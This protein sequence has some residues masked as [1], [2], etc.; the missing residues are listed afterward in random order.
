MRTIL[1]K[2]TCICVMRERPTLLSPHAWHVSSYKPQKPLV[3]NNLSLVL[4]FHKMPND[5]TSKVPAVEELSSR[6]QKCH[7]T[8]LKADVNTQDGRVVMTE[9]LPCSIECKSLNTKTRLTNGENMEKNEVLKEVLFFNSSYMM[10]NF[11]LSQVLSF[12]VFS[13]FKFRTVSRVFFHVLR[14]LRKVWS[15]AIGSRSSDPTAFWTEK[16][17]E[18]VF[19]CIKL[20]ILKSPY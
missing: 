19:S 9:V 13:I 11:Q 8:E 7:Y 14:H 16:I 15:S 6:G 18:I 1:P 10:L 20:L 2:W 3:S 5:C 4:A 17:T 12:D